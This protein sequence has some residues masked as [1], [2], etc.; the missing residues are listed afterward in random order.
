LIK[1]AFRYTKKLDT[2]SILLYKNMR[3]VRDERK[4]L[5]NI[6]RH[7]LDFAE[8]DGF[9][10][11]AATIRPAKARRLMAI[12]GFDSRMIVLGSEAYSIISMRPASAKERSLHGESE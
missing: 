12:G 3:I 6:Q 2:H 8:L 4:S 5:A 10:W 7:G 11:R 9:D 1:K